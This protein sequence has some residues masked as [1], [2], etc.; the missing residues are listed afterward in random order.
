MGT[1][2]KQESCLSPTA[3]TVPL[4]DTPPGTLRVPEGARVSS[5]CSAHH[6]PFR[7][8]G[9]V[10]AARPRGQRGALSLQARTSLHLTLKAPASLF[11]AGNEPGAT[12]EHLPLNT[13]GIEITTFHKGVL[14][15]FQQ[16]CKDFSGHPRGK[17]ERSEKSTSNGLSVSPWIPQP[18]C[19]WLPPNGP[20]IN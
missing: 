4:Q 5:V 10:Q 6:T 16:C 11:Q 17:R 2:R 15:G 3:V 9:T 14:T 12:E 18:A 20:I 19:P 7:L 8:N 13:E 1:K